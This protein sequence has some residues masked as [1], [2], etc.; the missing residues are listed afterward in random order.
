[1]SLR[2]NEGTWEDLDGIQ[3]MIEIMSIQYQ[4]L[5]FEEEQE[6]D[7][8]EDFEV[9]NTELK[10]KELSYIYEGNIYYYSEMN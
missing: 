3:G 2:G 4:S 8:H 10:V 1:M 9:K 6:M 7:V 5:K